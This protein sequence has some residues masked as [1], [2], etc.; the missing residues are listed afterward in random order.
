V[1]VWA[2]ENADD[3]IL[4]F[5]MSLNFCFGEWRLDVSNFW[6]VFVAILMPM[7]DVLMWMRCWKVQFK[8]RFSCQHCN[9]QVVLM[10][11]S[12]E[13]T[14]K[15]WWS[16]SLS[17]LLVIVSKLDCPSRTYLLSDQKGGKMQKSRD[18]FHH[19][20]NREQNTY[21]NDQNFMPVLFHVCKY[22]CKKTTWINST[23]SYTRSD[24]P[25]GW[26]V[27]LVAGRCELYHVP[28]TLAW[29]T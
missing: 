15:K 9:F 3:C 8:A 18:M 6:G 23:C 11:Q 13:Y 19:Q 25:S 28:A 27:F 20:W 1:D 2:C 17:Y 7:V 21:C 16:W 4:A 5:Y 10:R 22:V 26:G 29:I 14:R 12:M 24:R